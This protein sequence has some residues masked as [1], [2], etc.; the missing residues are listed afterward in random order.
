[1]DNS[2]HNW[3]LGRAHASIST[4]L[5]ACSPVARVLSVVKVAIR[6]KLRRKKAAAGSGSGYSGPVNLPEGLA[7]A[8]RKTHS[9]VWLDNAVKQEQPDDGGAPSPAVSARVSSCARR[10]EVQTVCRGHCCSRR[11]QQ[12]S[13]ITTSNVGVAP[14]NSI[15]LLSLA[16]LGRTAHSHN[17][18][19][20]RGFSILPFCVTWAHQRP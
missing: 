5:S 13:G 14:P 2:Q 20:L 8:M 11:L 18:R 4:V 19:S 10:L 15:P 16:V 6:N 9:Y 1:M 7:A 3:R 12:A 17:L